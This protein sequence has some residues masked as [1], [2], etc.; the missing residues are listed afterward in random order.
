MK[1]RDE[2]VMAEIRRGLQCHVHVHA[3][4]KTAYGA[5]LKYKNCEN[6]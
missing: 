4:V 3:A 5:F 1:H 2:S 6:L